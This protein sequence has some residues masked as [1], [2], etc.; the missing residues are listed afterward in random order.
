[1][2]KKSNADKQPRNSQNRADHLAP[3]K[4][5]PGQSGHPSGRPK[6][7]LPSDVMRE[8]AEAAYVGSDAIRKLQQDMPEPWKSKPVKDLTAYEIIGWIQIRRSMQAAADTA[9]RDFYDRLEGKPKMRI[10]GPD[11]GAIPVSINYNELFTEE[12]LRVV[13]EIFA[14]AMQRKGDGQT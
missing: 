6:G 13:R 7:K 12:E 3:Y 10:E 2:T 8:M 5:K 1:M 14:R 9:R 11:G 4:W